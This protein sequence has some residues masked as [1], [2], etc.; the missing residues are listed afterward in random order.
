M[1]KEKKLNL[2]YD[3]YLKSVVNVWAVVFR[4]ISCVRL[5]MTSTLSFTEQRRQNPPQKKTD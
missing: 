2:K 4:L 1:E 5:W 3:K